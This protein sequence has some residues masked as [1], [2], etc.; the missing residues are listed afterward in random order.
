MAHWN[1]ASGRCGTRMRRLRERSHLPSPPP[2]STTNAPPICNAFSHPKGIGK[3][4]FVIQMDRPGRQVCD[5]DFRCALSGENTTRSCAPFDSEAFANRG[6]GWAFSCWMLDV[7]C[8]MQYNLIK[9]EFARTHAKIYS[10]RLSRRNKFKF[11]STRVNKMPTIA[12]RR[13]FGNRDSY[14]GGGYV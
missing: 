14:E 1:I 3:V 13:L 10:L 12:D 2:H 6:W 4:R 11:D 8:H 5:L 9:T 7:R